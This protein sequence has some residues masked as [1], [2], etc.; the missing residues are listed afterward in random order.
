MPRETQTRP[1]S[2]NAA[3]AASATQ[4]STADVP[5]SFP[6]GGTLRLRGEGQAGESSQRRIRWAEN[7]VNNEGMGKK[8]SKICC[9]YHKP[10][11]VGE[12][13]SESSD[14]SSDSDSDSDNDDG[15]A[16]PSQRHAASH[17]HDHSNHDSCDHG[18]GKARKHVPNAYEKQ[19]KYTQRND[20]QP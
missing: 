5:H 3:P 9:I 6:T 13:S 19:P 11:E 4:T 14:S 16:K 12:S 20:S 15:A 2:N 1:G 7:V 17:G 18:K 8:K 10:R